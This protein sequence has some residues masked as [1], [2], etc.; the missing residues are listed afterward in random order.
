MN[1]RTRIKLL[2]L[3]FTFS[4]Q[5][6]DFLIQAIEEPAAA[7]FNFPHFALL[8]A[9]RKDHTY[10]LRA[11]VKEYDEPGR[12]IACTIDGAKMV[13]TQKAKDVINFIVAFNKTQRE[14]HASRYAQTRRNGDPRPRGRS[15]QSNSSADQGK[16]DTHR[17]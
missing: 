3:R 10:P 2:M 7:T 13:K 4:S 12:G 15:D 16:S 17:D 6:V 1:I 9:R 11:I 5:E 8:T 14:T